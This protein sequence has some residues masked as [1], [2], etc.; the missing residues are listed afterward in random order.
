MFPLKDK[1]QDMQTRQHEKYVVK[2]ANTEK[3]INYL[4]AEL[5]EYP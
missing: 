4:H 5:I 1:H 3:I 2:H